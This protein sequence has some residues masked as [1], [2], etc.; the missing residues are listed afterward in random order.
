MPPYFSQ[1]YFFAKNYTR[2]RPSAD[3]TK[4]FGLSMMEE[5]AS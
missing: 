4:C 5:D 2:T 1:L 3:L